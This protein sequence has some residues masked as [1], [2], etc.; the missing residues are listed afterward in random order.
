M[1]SSG[2]YYAYKKNSVIFVIDT[3]GHADHIAIAY[4]SSVA[5]QRGYAT[6][7][8]LLSG[9]DL[10]TMVLDI[11]PDIVAYSANV[12]S[13]KN[14][15]EHHKRAIAVHKFIS[16]LGG[17]QATFLPGS[18]KESGMD[19]Y[20]VGEG[21][22]AFGEFLDR[23]KAGQPFDDVLNLVTH[24]GANTVRPLISNLDTLPMPDRDLVLSNSF[25]K[26]ISKKNILHNERLSIFL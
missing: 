4:L 1:E 5:K 18:F 7:F 24:K 25:L 15:V 8:C 21:E 9:S 26:N 17:P 14:I 3:L 10:Q 22:E 16:I 19:A 13:F 2:Q 23:V 11:K 6:Y 20:C 12:V